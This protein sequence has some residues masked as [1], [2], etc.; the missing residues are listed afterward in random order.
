MYTQFLIINKI[1][2]LQKNQFFQR[3]SANDGHFKSV[4]FQ[5]SF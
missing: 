1:P 5:Q 3:T 4:N 2:S